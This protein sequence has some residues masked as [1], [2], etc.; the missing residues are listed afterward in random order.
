MPAKQ[1]PKAPTQQIDHVE[2]KEHSRTSPFGF[3]CWVG[4][5][6]FCLSPPNRDLRTTTWRL[7]TTSAGFKCARQRRPCRAA[8]RGVQHEPARV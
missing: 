3:G 8:R 2:E 6:V 4:A 1:L 5:V 7:T